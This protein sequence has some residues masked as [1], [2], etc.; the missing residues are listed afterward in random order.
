MNGLEPFQKGD[1]VLDGVSL[2]APKTDMSKLRSRVGM[3]FQHFELFPHLKVVENLCLAQQKVLAAAA[4]R[5]KPRASSFS[6]AWASR[7]MRTNSGPAFGRSAAARR[8]RALRSPWTRFVMLFDEPTSA[9]DPEMVSEVL[10]V[11]VELA[12]KA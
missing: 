7:R 12:R 1:I 5:R 11:M 2:T 8:H 6:S 4:T 9:L 3:V 10:D